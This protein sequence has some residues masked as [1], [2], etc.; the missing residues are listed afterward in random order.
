MNLKL[1]SGVIESFAHALDEENISDWNA[2]QESQ[3]R[4][5][6]HW[7]LEASE[8]NQMIRTC[9][10][11]DLHFWHRPD[12][13]PLK[14]MREYADINDDMVRSMYRDLYNEER[15]LTDRINRFI[16]QC[17]ELRRVDKLNKVDA[18][19]HWHDKEIVFLYLSFQYPHIYPLLIEGGFRKLLTHLKAKPLS[20]VLDIERYTKTSK[21]IYTFLGKS[22]ILG[23]KISELD[24][25][26]E[27]ACFSNMQTV[28]Q[29]YR[30]VDRAF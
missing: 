18:A 5:S 30:W 16:Y 13:Y 3:I 23:R 15:N 12:Y 17:D 2:L 4:Y 11:R 22:E 20:S 28:A 14:T 21:I 25:I 27:T 7:N 29:F 10:V 8:L 26:T 19:P 1:L 9:F 24:Q 6:K